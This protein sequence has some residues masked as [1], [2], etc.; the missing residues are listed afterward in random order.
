MRERAE[1]IKGNL[2]IQSAV[3]EGTVIVLEVPLQ[4]GEE[5]L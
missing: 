2:N 1:L 4:G 5:L 3:G